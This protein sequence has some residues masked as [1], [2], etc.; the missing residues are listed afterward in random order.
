MTPFVIFIAFFLIAVL[1]HD[2]KKDKRKDGKAPNEYGYSRH[3]PYGRP[4]TPRNTPGVPR[5]Q[6]A[7]PGQNR[8][9][10]T[11]HEVR[12][13]NGG[14]MHTTSLTVVRDPVGESH[15]EPI[16]PPRKSPLADAIMSSERHAQE[17]LGSTLPPADF[18]QHPSEAALHADAHIATTPAHPTPKTTARRL[19]FELPKNQDSLKKALLYSEI[20]GKPKALGR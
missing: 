7:V 15:A 8:V 2:Y 3:H 11:D 14:V 9:V 20:L 19:A 16:P 1:S 6:R 18:P 12:T 17:H 10:R 4:N 5:N 13:P